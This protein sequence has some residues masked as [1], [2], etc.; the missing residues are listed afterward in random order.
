MPQVETDLSASRHHQ[1]ELAA[2]EGIH[3]AAER[4]AIFR[5]AKVE[6]FALEHHLGQ[7]SFSDLQQAIHTN[8]QL[9]S[10]ESAQDKYTTQEA[11]QRELA[12]LR[13]MQQGQGK[14]RSLVTP[15]ELKGYLEN[16][17][18]TPG[19]R[20]A[21]E[22]AATTP[23]RVVAW[24]G[25]AGAGKTYSLQLFR[26]IA[27]TQG[28]SIKGYAPSAQAAAVLAQET[29]MPSDTVASL[30]HSSDPPSPSPAEIWVIDEAGLLSAKD[31]HTLL[32]KAEHQ[33][34]RVL[35]VGDTRQLS[36]VEAGNPFK[37]LQAGGMSTAYLDQSLRQ[38]TQALKESV[39]LV[40]VGQVAEG[41]RR[42]DS[43]GAIEAI[44]QSGQ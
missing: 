10:I 42:L 22:L 43:T 38:K 9:I 15:A 17:S 26:T 7:Q 2:N 24:Q 6:R 25:V 39:D 20:Q 11:I 27:Q 8:P 21:V 13:L 36:A 3:H 41:L 14:A 34:A 28:Y 18:L 19:Q 44:P 23:D 5:Q 1:A 31:A 29:G 40:A 37:S 32:Q 30:T 16:K 12:T 33:R 35:L 4:E